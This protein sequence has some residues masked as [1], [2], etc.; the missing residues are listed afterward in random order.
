MKKSIVIHCVKNGSGGIGDFIRSS[1]YFYIFCKKNNI[2]YYID[3]SNYKYFN[4]CFELE[5]IPG[6]ITENFSE[7]IWFMN[8]I[9][10]TNNEIFNTII[11]QPKT[12]Y[13][14]SNSFNYVDNK[15]NDHYITEY[16]NKVLRP[17]K[18][19]NNYIDFIY[20][21]FKLK[22][23]N[24]VSFHLR[25]GDTVMCM[26]DNKNKNKDKNHILFD[27]HNEEEIYN[28]NNYIEQFLTKHKINMPVI[29][30]SDSQIIKQKLKNKNN[31]LI[32][33]ENKIRHNSEDIGPDTDE[34]NTQTVAEFY[35]IAKSY[36]IL[37]KTY[38]GFSHYASFV[39][40]KNIYTEL[41]NHEYYKLFNR[42]NI[43]SI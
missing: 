3:F 35:L 14:F 9:G 25:C 2:E 40:K 32:I 39:Y 31:N 13:L 1:I 6:N 43:Y 37:A 24:Y 18:K 10:K 4:E 36:C 42:N 26:N 20:N 21:Q 15:E 19:V 11:K 34:A 33:L 29:I 22:K 7:S 27:I 23:D 30:H 17:S 16:F 38:S 28:L 8:S 41:F 5:K 12:Y